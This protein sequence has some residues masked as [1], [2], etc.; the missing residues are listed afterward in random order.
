MMLP[1]LGIAGFLAGDMDQVAGICKHQNIYRFI[2]VVIITLQGS[3]S[4][5]V[6]DAN[7]PQGCQDV[8][9]ANGRNSPFRT[10]CCC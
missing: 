2:L 4:S 3:F 10:A 7:P 1:I 5:L 9:S 8:R 6:V